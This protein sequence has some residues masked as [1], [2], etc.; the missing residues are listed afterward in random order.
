MNKK[1]VSPLIATILLVVIAV[2]LGAFVMNFGKNIEAG[3]Y[4]I[5]ECREFEQL[6]FDMSS[7]KRVCFQEIAPIIEPESVNIGR[8]E[9]I[10]E[11]TREIYNL[12]AK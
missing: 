4:V 5:D 9:L 12:N 2:A 11:K 8:I 1:G 3:V 7:N 10:K 6:Q